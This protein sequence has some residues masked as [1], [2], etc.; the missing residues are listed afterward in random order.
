MSYSENKIETIPDV[1]DFLSTMQEYC[2][3]DTC[4]YCDNVRQSIKTLEQVLK[5][6]NTIK[7]I[8]N[9]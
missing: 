3:E 7:P 1:I 2:E 9:G 8:G 6:A 4:T 5:N